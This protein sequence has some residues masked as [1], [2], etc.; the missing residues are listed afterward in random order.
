MEYSL[1]DRCYRFGGSCCIPVQLY[2]Y[3]QNI[4]NNFLK[5][6]VPIHQVTLCHMSK[7]S[8]LRVTQIYLLYRLLYAVYNRQLL[9]LKE[10]HFGIE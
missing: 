1:V 10:F 6:L 8:G 2:K 3:S 7:D 4:G 5:I 9:R